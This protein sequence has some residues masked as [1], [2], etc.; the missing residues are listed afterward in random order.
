MP[1]EYELGHIKGSIHAVCEARAKEIRLPK[2]P[3][4]VKIVLIDN[5]ETRSAA[6]ATMMRSEG[7]D[8]HYLKGCMKNWTM[9]LVTGFPPQQPLL[10]IFQKN[11]MNLI[12]I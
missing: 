4:N 10:A 7:F 9:D 5:D 1:V 6:T 3:K 8:S 2:I 12:C 11:Y